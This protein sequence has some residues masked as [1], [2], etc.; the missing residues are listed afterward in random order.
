MVSRPSEI[1]KQVSFLTLKSYLINNKGA[2]DCPKFLWN[3]PFS[4]L[5]HL[6]LPVHE[7]PIFPGPL[8][9]HPTDLSKYACPLYSILYIAARNI[10][11]SQSN[12]VP[13]LP[14]T[15]NGSLLPLE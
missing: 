8:Q 3:H 10:L 4:S 14:K 5:L 7:S 13:P 1:C 6:T 9:C 11:S 12:L 2:F 15:F